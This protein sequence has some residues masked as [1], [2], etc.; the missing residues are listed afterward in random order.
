MA[1]IV[2]IGAGVAGLTS[3]LLLARKYPTIPITIVAKHMP[4]DSDPEY[5]SPIAGADFMPMSSPE[6]SLWERETWPEL[7]KLAQHVPEAGI[8]FQP[9]RVYKR[10]K[11]LDEPGQPGRGQFDDNP[12]FRSILDDYRE[13]ETGE[14]PPGVV[15]GFE[16]RSVC[17]NTPLYLGWLVGQCR[18]AGIVL[19]RG[20]IEHVSDARNYSHRDNIAN[21]VINCT[22]LGSSRLGGVEDPQVTPIRGQVVLIRNEIDSMYTISG[23]DDGPDEISYCMARAS[24]G[25]TVVGGSYQMH[26]WDTTP[27]LD[28]SARMLHRITELVP[29]LSRCK[30]VADLDIVRHAVGLRPYRS[31]GVRVERELLANGLHVVHNYG[32]SGWGFQGSYGCGNRVLELVA[33]IV[34]AV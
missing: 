19:R 20:T 22:G 17:I 1:T 32:H 13:L 10:E 18:R 5:A 21:I 33:E 4:G 31:T 25:G 34:L 26:N 12:W 7:K 23:T 28:M 2:V 15:S 8:H 9:I 27:D 11:D 14:L 24:G 30:G 16:F 29:S 6:N 3:G